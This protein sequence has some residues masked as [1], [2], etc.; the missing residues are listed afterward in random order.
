MD[1]AIVQRTED[2]F[3]VYEASKKR[4]RRSSI[5]WEHFHK[6]KDEIDD[7]WKTQCKHCQQ[8]YSSAQKNGTS[9]LKR[10]LDRCPKIGTSSLSLASKITSATK[11][12]LVEYE[13]NNKRS[14]SFS[15]VWEDFEKLKAERD[16]V[17]K[18]RCRHCKQILSGASK[19]GTSHLK[20]H[21]DRC[22]KLK[23]HDLRQLFL[24]SEARDV[25]Q[26]F[27][28]AETLDEGST[29]FK[30]VKLDQNEILKAISAFIVCGRHPITV[31][32]EFGFRHLMSVVCPEIENLSPQTMK[33]DI[34]SSYVKEREKLKELFGRTPGR[35]CL[36]CDNWS[37]N[38]GKDEYL[39][40]SAHFMS[41]DWKLVR[42]IIHFKSLT[43]PLDGTEIADE[44]ALCLNL[45]N[46]NSKIFSI[47]SDNAPYMDSMV[48]SLRRAIL[49]KKNILCDGAFFQ[50]QCCCHVLNYIVRASLNVVDD[51]IDKIR[52]GIRYV[53]KSSSRK[54]KFYEMASRDFHLDAKKRLRPDVRFWWN[55]TYTMIDCALYYRGALQ[56]WGE[57]ES[58]F[59]YYNLYDE[60][61]EKLAIIQK[62]L[63]VLYDVQCTFAS[64]EHPT[65]NHY[66]RAV[67]KVYMHLLKTARG[68][69]AFMNGMI[70]DVHK[71]FEKYWAE[72]CVILSCAAVL[73]P[74]YKVK[75]IEFCF[76]KIYG[77]KAEE[78]VNAT[79]KALYSLFD[80]Y[81]TNAVIN[82]SST[83]A[84]AANLE[85]VKA[86]DEFEDYELFLSRKSRTQDEK[87]QL[88][89]YLEEPSHDL[90]SDL[91]ILEF[92]SK[93]SM[94]YPELAMMARDVL[95]IPIS[96]VSS[97]E[98]FKIGK[99]LLNTCQCSLNPKVFQS[100]ICLSDWTCSALDKSFLHDYDDPSVS[101]EEDYQ[102][103]WD[104]ENGAFY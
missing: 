30:K 81:K 25:K 19:Y 73:D 31:V 36:T 20:R 32:D 47:T 54:K 71:K 57:H 58:R 40:I 37:S 14:R 84:I 39:R 18:A 82:S 51:V 3:T 12:G 23:N 55:T 5:V 67:W 35:I 75:L 45:W 65:S 87:S 68:P 101:D 94:R 85:G 78:F 53:I 28:S 21:L 60:E 88:D 91:D 100:L 52:N 7:V 103:D 43:I 9:H 38:Y 49:A 42:K 50:V 13:T 90:N 34:M 92:W 17:L 59:I 1:C 80:K 63:S 46:I 24:S 98:S 93:S 22:P 26:L 104:T 70:E 79:V 27:L 10:H 89:L 48:I 77:D 61:W 16:D 74:R 96:S 29:P 95:T 102:D 33:R 2:D 72:S 41:N 15:K 44:V 97:E 8:I 6:L 66:F 62:F 86:V 11:G 99:K 56:S 83:R 64:M 76:T 4:G 69:Y